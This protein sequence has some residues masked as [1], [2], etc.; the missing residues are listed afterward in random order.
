LQIPLTGGMSSPVTTVTGILGRHLDAFILVSITLLAALL[1]LWGLGDVPQGIHGDEAQFG[2][3]AERVLSEG[4]IGPYTGSAL[5]QPSGI[6]YVIAPAQWLLGATP[7][8]VRLGVAI[9][10]VAAIP[11]AYVLFRLLTNR[12][13]ALLAALLLAVS[14]WHV[15]LSRVAYQPA[16]VPTIELAVLVFWALAIQRGNWYWFVLSGATLGLGLYTYTAYP[17]FVFAFAVYIVIY[18]LAFKR[19]AELLPWV[20]KVGFAALASFIVGLP[21]F[22]YMSDPAN[23]YFSHYR[24]YYESHSLLQSDDFEQA[25]LAAK[26]DLV[27]NKATNF[28]GAYAWHGVSDFIDGASPDKRP[29]LDQVTLALLVV[30]MVSVFWHWREPANLLSLVM[31]AVIPLSSIL[32]TN[33]TYRGPL[34]A[35][36]FVA[37]FV[38]VPLALAWAKAPQLASNYRWGAFALVPLAIAFIAYT[39]VHAYFGTWSK[40]SAF[41]WVYSQEVTA[42]SEYIQSLPNNPYVYFYSERW[43]F[44]YETRK[45]LAPRVQGENRSKQHGQQ[46]GYEIDRSRDSVLLLLPPY[47]ADQD[48]LR[49]MYPEGTESVGREG[50]RAL[51]LAYHVPAA[52]NDGLTNDASGSAT[53]ADD[54]DARR[55]SDLRGIAEALDGYR[56]EHGA[57]PSTNGNVQTACAYP[58]LDRLCVLEGRTGDAKLVDPRGHATELGYWYMSDGSSFTLFATL[59]KPPTQAERCTPV[60]ESLRQKPNVLCLRSGE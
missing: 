54:S 38:A 4:W 23:D 51:Y 10:S 35:V 6:A 30:G 15:H 32:Q 31:L 39:S 13:T 5:G 53:P 12:V 14:L 59:E 47:I 34:G 55:R 25:N 26:L 9:F 27:F 36:P 20:R 41:R 46:Q 19:G 58:T 49:T 42:A 8:G 16:L 33:A 44:D 60:P 18:T 45:Y 21:L 11:L 57:Y 37:Y 3:D 22:L 50:E 17:I 7:L 1:R 56:Q 52:E 29:M 28:I 24:Y 40:S 43:S 2:M 48:L